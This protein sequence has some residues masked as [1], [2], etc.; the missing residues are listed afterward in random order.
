MPPHR[1]WPLLERS[2]D[3][4]HLASVRAVIDGPPGIAAFDADGTLWDGDV[5][6]AL[7]EVLGP[8]G[9]LVAPHPPNPFAE[10]ARR[11]ELDPADGFGYATAVMAGM[12][13]AAVTAE[14]ER[15]FGRFHDR[16]FP[17]VRELLDGLRERGWEIFLVSASNRWSIAP[18]AR[19]LGVPLDH[20][21]AVDVEVEAGRLTDRVCQPVPTLA[22][23]PELVRRHAGRAPDLACG[24][25]R[26]DLPLL[27]SARLPI[28][29]GPRKQG[30][31]LLDDARARGWAR[32][33]VDPR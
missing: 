28:A 22:G 15:I 24:N 32:L 33:W 9:K 14:A 16:F 27:E 10:Y 12:T 25:S 29:V 20:V 4:D 8:S 3:A 11:L 13:E 2:L 6:E 7:L 26:L 21:L 17:P 5:G 30:S 23:K 31:A 19:A 1:S 18:G